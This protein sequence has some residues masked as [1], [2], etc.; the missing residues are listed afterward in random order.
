M[1]RPVYAMLSSTT[2]KIKKPSNQLYEQRKNL[3]SGSISC[4]G[5]IERTQK[6]NS[7]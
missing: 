7:T 4:S 2:N 6:V 5:G 3:D 1:N